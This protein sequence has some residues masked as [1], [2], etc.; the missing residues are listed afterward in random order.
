[1]GNLDS[2]SYILD[3]KVDILYKNKEMSL[4][5]ILAFILQK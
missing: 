2:N 4:I 3:F 5:D 1:M